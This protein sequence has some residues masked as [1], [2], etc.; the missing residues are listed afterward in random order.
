MIQRCTFEVCLK[1]V[2][3]PAVFLFPPEGWMWLE[4]REPGVRDGLYCEPH[5]KALEALFLS[6]ELGQTQ[7]PPTRR[8]RRMRR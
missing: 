2:E 6:G 5:G 7:R 4:T 3:I 1:S 8:P